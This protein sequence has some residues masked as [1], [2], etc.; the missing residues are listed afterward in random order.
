M[1]AKRISLELMICCILS[2][3]F[4]H[5]IPEGYEVRQLYSI[6]GNYGAGEEISSRLTAAIR[7]ALKEKGAEP[8]KISGLRCAA[9]SQTDRITCAIT[10]ERRSRAAEISGLL[11]ETVPAAVGWVPFGVLASRISETKAKIDEWNREVSSFD[12]ELAALEPQIADARKKLDAIRPQRTGVETDLSNRK[13]QIEILEEAIPQGV[14][15]E[16]RLRYEAKKKEVVGILKDLAARIDSMD[17]EILQ[18]S[19]PLDRKQKIEESLPRLRAQIDTAR[20][21][22]ASW[23]QILSG[24]TKGSLLADPDGFQ[25]AALTGSKSMVPIRSWRHL[26]WSF[27]LGLLFLALIRRKRL[28][29][30]RRR[31]FQ[32]PDEVVEQTGLPFL[33]TM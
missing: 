29:D 11:R 22:T 20:A 1:T 19:T 16:T 9:A 12:G 26:P 8:E 10:S 30:W 28:S 18:L 6:T 24:A 7:A 25:L 32:S 3:G 31:Y 14:G 23:N 17:R 4:V 13:R 21:E 27:P 15:S 33:G 2:A 5:A